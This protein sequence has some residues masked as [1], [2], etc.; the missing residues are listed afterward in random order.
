[1]NI[2]LVGPPGSGKG[3]Q[4]SVLSDRLSIPHISTGDMFRYHLKNN[5]TLGSEANVYIKKGALVPD[6]ITN[7]MVRERLSENDV[8][9]GFIL[10]GYPRN[11]NQTFYLDKVLSLSNKK[12]D[13]II[14]IDVNDQIIINRISGRRVCTVCGNIT[15]ISKNNTEICEKCGGTVVLRSDDKEEVVKDRLT[16]YKNETE[17][18]IQHYLHNSDVN[19]I[20]V[21]GSKS[22]SVVTEEILKHLLGK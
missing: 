5:T 19:L 6:V 18:V 16:V 1:M 22:P 3:T 8:L 17:P 20:K 2:I 7:N 12:I 9:N 11:V 15:H 10:D 4:A 13:Y 14:Y 21:D